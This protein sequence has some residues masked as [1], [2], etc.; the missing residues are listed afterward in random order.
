MRHFIVGLL[1]ATSACTGSIDDEEGGGTT[2]PPRTDVRVQVRDGYS[3]Q[4][5]VRVIFQAADDT[6][7][8]D[9]LTD[10][11]GIAKA[12]MA[13]GSVTVIR[14]FPIITPPPPEGQ[15]APEIYTYVGV[16][17]GDLLTLGDATSTRA[18]G[19]IV[20]TVP[21][22]AQGTVK[23]VTPCGSGQGTAPN[24][25][26]TVTDCPPMVGFLVTDD[27]QSSF[28]QE[29]AY[30][31]NIDLST[32]TLAGNLAATLSATNVP[33]NTT[34]NAEERVVTGSYTLYRSGEKRIDEQ[35][36]TVDLPNLTGVEQ[37][38]VARIA[39]QGMGTQLVVARDTYSASPALID[40]SANLIPYIMGNPTYAPTGVSW[41]QAGTGTADAVFVTLNV[42]RG[43]A[44]GGT[45]GLDAE[46][47]RLII[48][49]HA[50]TS[51]R[52]PQL[53][54]AL[55]N[56]TSADQMAGTAGLVKTTGGYDAIRAKAF[57]VESIVDATPASGKL[58][59]SYSGNT[60]PGR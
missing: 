50:G 14:S 26:I 49:P 37:L 18:P 41:V 29:A 44:M 33:P 54:D 15:R 42:T 56:P 45:P 40:A 55:Y 47:T 32:G 34:V 28:F 27:Q 2:E 43:A 19:A 48:A 60:P 31:E 3:P 39:T 12:E 8:A 52:M 16:K 30:A 58:V 23:V 36:A 21:V 13:A 10:A 9:T 11:M 57:A 6:V 20:V 1:L 24:I 7:I 25:A 35:P 38:V 59:L 46:Y 4:A 51:L 53:P 22:D 17:N 5:S